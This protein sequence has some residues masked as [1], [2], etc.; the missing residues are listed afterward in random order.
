MQTLDAARIVEGEYLQV[1]NGDRKVVD[2]YETGVLLVRAAATDDLLAWSSAESHPDTLRLSPLAVI[3]FTYSF[4]ELYR[5]F[6][7]LLS[8]QP[9][10]VT[11]RLQIE[12]AKGDRTLY[13]FP[14]GVNAVHW[15]H[16]LDHDRHPAPSNSKVWE[17]T[18]AAGELKAHPAIVAYQ[19]V[20]R[21]YFWFGLQIEEIPYIK[22]DD[23]V[24][25][26]DVE[27]VA[28]GGK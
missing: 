14:Y 6:I 26:I 18:I 9:A 11:L 25:M 20:E 22:T 5:K 13:M 3:E 7:E 1:R 16:P 4:V 15:Q 24:R 19:L 23:N 8:P 10:L 2:L 28:R 12:N 21:I 27:M 17:F